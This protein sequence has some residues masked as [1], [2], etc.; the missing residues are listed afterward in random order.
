LVSITAESVRRRV[1]LTADDVPDPIVTQHI[2][3]AA[4]TIELKTGIVISSSDCTNA[5]AVGIRNLAGI[6][7][8]CYVTRGS[9]SGLDYGIGDL[10]VEQVQGSFCGK[11]T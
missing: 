3:E 6:Y 9:A 7:C 8:I 10:T 11:S 2:Q 5:H 1:H 4:A